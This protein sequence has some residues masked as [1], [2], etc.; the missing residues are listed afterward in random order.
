[1]FELVTGDLLFDP[2]EGKSWDREEDHLAMMIELLGDFPRSM[3]T[4][5]KY[6]SEYFNR[7]GELKHIHSLKYWGLRDVLRDKYRLTDQDA[8][9]LGAFLSPLLMVDPAERATAQ[10]ALVHPWLRV[11]GQGGQG[12]RGG[13][14]KA[15]AK[16]RSSAPGTGGS[17]SGASAKGCK[18]SVQAGTHAHPSDE[19]YSTGSGTGTARSSTSA[20]TGTGT[21]RAEGKHS[22]AKDGL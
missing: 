5:G 21:S 12:G 8:L 17:S 20:S 19:K 18:D 15:E 1:V 16:H 3:T 9:E 4:A 14:A 2:Q 6:G 22:D 11:Q 10:E 13:E 7:K